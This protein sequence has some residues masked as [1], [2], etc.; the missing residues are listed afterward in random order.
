MQSQGK[1]Q[2]PSTTKDPKRVGVKEDVR[3]AKSTASKNAKPKQGPMRTGVKEDVRG[4]KSAASKKS[5]PKQGAMRTGVKEDV[6]A[7]GKKQITK[8]GKA[9]QLRDGSKRK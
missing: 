9:G 3:S 8:S 7:T 2:K 4:T 1:Q 6:R 5:K